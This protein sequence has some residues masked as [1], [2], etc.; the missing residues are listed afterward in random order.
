MNYVLEPAPW[1]PGR[2]EGVRLA[3]LWKEEGALGDA[4]DRG[5]TPKAPQDVWVSEC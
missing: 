3:L 4:V 1:R 5:S 2:G